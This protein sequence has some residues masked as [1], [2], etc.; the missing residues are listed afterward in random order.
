MFKRFDRFRS[1]GRGFRGRLGFGFV[2]HD[3]FV[4]EIVIFARNAFDAGFG[5]EPVRAAAVAPSVAW[6]RKVRRERALRCG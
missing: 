6:R 3:G 4:D 5:G 1:G 2:G